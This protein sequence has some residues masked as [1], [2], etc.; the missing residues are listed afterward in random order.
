LPFLIP[1]I[2]ESELRAIDKETAISQPHISSVRQQLAQHETELSQMIHR[3]TADQRDSLRTIIEYLSGKSYSNSIFNNSTLVKL[4]IERIDSRQEDIR[5]GKT[6]GM[7]EGM[8]KARTERRA[9]EISVAKQMVIDGELT[10]EQMEKFL[11]RM[12]EDENK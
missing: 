4:M 2:V 1:F 5:W 6:E 9:K 10:R 12:D 7:A 11:K 3:L 8:A